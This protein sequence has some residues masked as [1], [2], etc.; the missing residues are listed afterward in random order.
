MRNLEECCLQEYM[1]FIQSKLFSKLLIIG[2]ALVLLMVPVV[3]TYKAF[4]KNSENEDSL[5][6]MQKNPPTPEVIQKTEEVEEIEYIY[7]K[8]SEPTQIP[9]ISPN[10]QQQIDQSPTITP[11]SQQ[12]IRN[13]EEVD[14]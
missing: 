14:D 9:V 2:P 10:T 12:R 8:T 11:R 7:S 1:Q 3:A 13:E 5:I 4:S 6:N